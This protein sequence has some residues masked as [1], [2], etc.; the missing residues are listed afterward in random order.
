MAKGL[1]ERVLRYYG[2]LCRA[3]RGLVRNGTRGLSLRHAK[4][5]KYLRPGELCMAVVR[6]VFM[7][8]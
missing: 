6:M 5:V 3:S 1:A 2:L 8:S 7:K 4:K